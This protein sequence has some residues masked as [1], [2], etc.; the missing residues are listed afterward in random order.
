M[1]GDM[2]HDV[3]LLIHL[4]DTAPIVADRLTGRHVQL[5]R[6]QIAEW[7]GLSV[8]T[9]S[10]Y[11]TGV[12]N[13][14]VGFWRDLL[15]RCF[16]PRIVALLTGDDAAIEVIYQPLSR[17]PTAR[18]FFR[19]AVETEGAH[20]EQMKQVAELLADGRVDELDA[21]TVQ[22]YSDAWYRHRLVDAQLH[23]SIMDTYQR[24][25]TKETPR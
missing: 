18:D 13:I 19:Q 1:N 22:A 20:H 12:R 17:E 23:R 5:S 25:V 8:Q 7:T 10:D 15:R 16:D 24:A 11:G 2:R 14:P 9:I 6:K 21:R 4:C 3:D